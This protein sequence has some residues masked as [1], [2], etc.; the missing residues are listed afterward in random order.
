MARRAT[1]GEVLLDMRSVRSRSS[2]SITCVGRRRSGPNQVSPPQHYGWSDLSRPSVPGC[3]PHQAGRRHQRSSVIMFHFEGE[4]RPHASA[5]HGATLT[6]HRFSGPSYRL[7]HVWS[8]HGAGGHCQDEGACFS[9][10]ARVAQDSCLA[11][12]TCHHHTAHAHLGSAIPIRAHRVSRSRGR[13]V[14]TAHL[15]HVF[16]GLLTLRGRHLRCINYG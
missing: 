6:G 9:T 10:V 5:G 3:L 4:H 13:D 7:T 8:Y 2:R 15:L 16:Y 12:S 11:Q 14:R 1:A